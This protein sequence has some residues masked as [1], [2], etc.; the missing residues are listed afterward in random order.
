M[1]L[2]ILDI[3]KMCIKNLGNLYHSSFFVII[4][5]RTS[6]SVKNSARH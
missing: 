3:K 5:V 6:L 1:Q 4:I 2:I